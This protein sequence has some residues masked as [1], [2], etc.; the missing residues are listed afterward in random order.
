MSSEELRDIQ[1]VALEFGV[2][3]VPFMDQIRQ[4]ALKFGKS[5]RLNNVKFK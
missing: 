1:I 2:V 3:K 5:L 4:I